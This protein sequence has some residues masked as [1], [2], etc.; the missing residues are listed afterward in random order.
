MKH[1]IVSKNKGLVLLHYLH[2]EERLSDIFFELIV[3]FRDLERIFF[4]LLKIVT[5][6]HNSVALS[7]YDSCHPSH[8][9]SNDGL[10]VR[11]YCLQV[12]SLTRGIVNDPDCISLPC[13]RLAHQL[14]LDS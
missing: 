3:E 4:W 14:K 6:F 1:F 5:S 7:D 2:P 10:K 13:G 9:I 8:F 12:A 11:E